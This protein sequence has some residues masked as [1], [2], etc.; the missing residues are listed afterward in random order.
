MKTLFALLAIAVVAVVCFQ[1]EKE[2]SYCVIK[3]I[4]C[5]N[6]CGGNGLQYYVCMD[7]CLMEREFCYR[8]KNTHQT[9]Q[10]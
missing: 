8:M 10:H 6:S 2:R 1:T 9:W 3:Y 5:S 4:K 7:E